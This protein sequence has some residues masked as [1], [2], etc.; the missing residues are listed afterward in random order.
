MAL[1]GGG[2]CPLWGHHYL[3]S[4]KNRSFFFFCFD[5]TKELMNCYCYFGSFYVCNM[6]IEHHVRIYIIKLSSDMIGILSMYKLCRFESI[7]NDKS[8]LSI[9]KL[10]TLFMFNKLPLLFNLGYCTKQKQVWNVSNN[11]Q[12]DK[13][14]TACRVRAVY[15]A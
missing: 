12:L 1:G 9:T 15:I 3:W 5:G 7:L 8:R 11:N 14:D 10:A 2:Y 4:P 13:F 6:N